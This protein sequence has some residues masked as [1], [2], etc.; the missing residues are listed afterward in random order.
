M[1]TMRRSPSL[2]S[3]ALPT[4]CSAIP[5]S[6]HH[7]CYVW[8][9][10]RPHGGCH[11]AAAICLSR[12]AKATSRCV[13]TGIWGARGGRSTWLR[14]VNSGLSALL[15]HLVADRSDPLDPDLDHVAG[16]E[17]FAASGANPGRR[18]GQDQIAGMKG[19][20]RRKMRDLLGEAEDHLGGVRILLDG[21][22]DPQL[23]GE[24]LRVW[25]LACR[26][27]PGAQRAGAVEALVRDPIG[28]ERRGIRDMRSA[29][30]ITRRKVVGDGVASDIA[31]CL[32]E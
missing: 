9:P 18:P 14:R 28:L 31:Q 26:H 24:V 21:A 11:A 5:V 25:A 16:L 20:P 1:N 8:S 19:Q 30:A 2:S 29:P 17:E 32:V 3:D 22:V 4:N 27:D 10:L 15:S 12:C 6:P 23:D 7:P 13:P